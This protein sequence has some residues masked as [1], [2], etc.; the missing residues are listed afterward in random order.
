MKYTVTRKPSKN[1]PNKKK[2][3]PVKKTTKN[4]GL[5]GQAKKAA[6]ALKKR[7]AKI[8]RT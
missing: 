5:T 4:K 6:D 7:N 8:K 3:K 1:N 2:R